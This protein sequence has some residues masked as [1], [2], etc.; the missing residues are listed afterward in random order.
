MEESILTTVKKLIGLE[1]LY[2]QF[3]L[4]IIIGINSAFSALRQIGVGPEGGFSIQDKTAVWSDFTDED[5]DL[6]SVKTYVYLKTRLVF[7]P[8]SSSSI[9]DSIKSVIEEIEWRLSIHNST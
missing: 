6:E 2:T 1:E 8:P 5:T 9:I 4:D 3:D 7:D